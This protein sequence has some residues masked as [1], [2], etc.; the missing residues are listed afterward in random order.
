[1]SLHPVVNLG[2]ALLLFSTA[3]AQDPY[4]RLVACKQLIHE[5]RS[6]A[7]AEP[8]EDAVAR[9]EERGRQQVASLEQRLERVLAASGW[10]GGSAEIVPAAAHVLEH[11]SGPRELQLQ[12]GTARARLESCRNPDS[13]AGAL[14]RER[15]CQQRVVST[16]DPERK[17]EYEVCNEFVI[18]ARHHGVEKAFASYALG[19]SSH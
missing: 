5:A 2:A 12:L 8:W 16:W 14:A 1:M 18:D 6:C 15:G 4:E 10:Q 3:C 9:C 19:P 11:E 7:D 17:F 13:I